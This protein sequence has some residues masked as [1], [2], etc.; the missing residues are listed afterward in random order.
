MITVSISLLGR[1]FSTCCLVLLGFY[2][3]FHL[4]HTPLFILPNSW[5]ISKYCM[6]RLPFLILKKRLY[7]GDI[8]WGSAVH[9]PLVTKA[10]YALGGPPCV[11]Y[12]GPSVVASWLV[13]ESWWVGLASGLGGCQ[14]LLLW[15]QAHSLVVWVLVWLTTWLSSTES[16]ADLMVVR[17][18][19]GGAGCRAWGILGLVLANFW[20]GLI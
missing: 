13:Q 16:G 14:P 17:L 1:C 5:F 7:L 18:C 15:L 3:F 11:S 12:V 9:F 19:T 10:I 8:L 4:E 2:L 20:L 6:A